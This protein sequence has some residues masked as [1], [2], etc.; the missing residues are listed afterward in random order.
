MCLTCIAYQSWI[1]QII[2]TTK[3]MF[4]K[5]E[6]E[7]NGIEEF[8]IDVNKDLQKFSADV[9]S[10]VA[11]G[12]SYEEGKEIF[13][14]QDQ[15]CHL[16]SLSIRTAYFPGFRYGIKKLNYIKHIIVYRTKFSCCSLVVYL[17]T[18]TCDVD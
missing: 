17:S 9:I 3:L 15:H 2:D 13:K 7:N 6:D 12:S 1:P 14:L 18:L 5:W 16:A 10:K 4:C 8:E 11:F